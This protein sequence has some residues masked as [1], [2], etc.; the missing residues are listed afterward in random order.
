VG[1]YERFRNVLFPS[2]EYKSTRVTVT[3]Q[4]TAD[5][6]VTIVAIYAS[7]ITNVFIKIHSFFYKF[8]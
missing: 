2:L 6:I 1:G 7:V 5:I 4:T 3:T 8:A